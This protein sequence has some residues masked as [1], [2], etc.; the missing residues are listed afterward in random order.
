[1]P[2]TW[3]R[4]RDTTAVVI[5][6]YMG[7]CFIWLSA[8]RGVGAWAWALV[9]VATTEWTVVTSVPP[10]RHRWPV[11]GACINIFFNAVLEPQFQC[12]FLGHRVS[13]LANY[14]S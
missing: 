3:R 12:S 11:H 8:I 9:A 5:G 4:G 13:A 10:E 7:A 6:D 1:V 2:I 14:M